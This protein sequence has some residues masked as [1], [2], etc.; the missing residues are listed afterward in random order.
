VQTVR[1]SGHAPNA[2]SLQIRGVNI[3]LMDGSSSEFLLPVIDSAEQK[4]DAKRR[5]RAQT[6]SLKTKRKGLEARQSIVVSEDKTEDKH[7][8]LECNVV[9]QQPSLWIKK[10]SLSHGTVMLYNGE[11]STIKITLENTS[12]VPVDFIKLSFED[13]VSREAQNI[14]AEGEVPPEKAYDLDNDSIQRPVFS[15]DSTADINIPAGGRTTINIQVLGKVGCTDGLIRIDYGYVNRPTEVFHTR[16][17]AFPVLFTVYST[18]E[19]YGLDLITL[20]ADKPKKALANG[21]SGT[22]TAAGG[23]GQF[24]PSASDELRSVLTTDIN[25]VLLCVNVRNVYS[26]PFEVAFNTK[27]TPDQ[28]AGARVT[29]LVPPGATEHIVLPV[30]RQA[31]GVE[32]RARPIP[33][34]NGRQFTVDKT[35]RSAEQVARTRELF[36][37]RERLLSLVSMV[38]REPGSLR[39]G[40]LT[41]SDQPLSP[42]QLDQ[43][44]LDQLDVTLSINS[45]G[46]DTLQPTDFV[47]LCVT[48]AN[49][50]ERPLRPYVRLEALPTS[51]TGGGWNP[52]APPPRRSSLPATTQALPKTVAFDGVLCTT[53]QTL[54]PGESAMHTVGAVLLAA[55]SYS[56]RAAAEEVVMLA[57]T[58]APLVCFSRPVS[59][60]VA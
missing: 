56:F 20:R 46:A 45:R 55:G 48:V 29:R 36:W 16:Q 10:T 33:L 24:A 50:L 3:H 5:S 13:A 59:V 60:D 2:G 38:W 23:L 26:V 14:L 7:H 37:L 43:F 11:T 8:W 17:L 49:N 40:N 4:R 51:S 47:D 18:L 58:E 32:E 22:A 54:A 44:R 21:T 41:L 19:C 1:V 28:E 34:P 39:S 57:P 53:L 12:S 30:P 52:A 35:K 6:E 42:S 27:P 25:S 15:W 31:L 9:D